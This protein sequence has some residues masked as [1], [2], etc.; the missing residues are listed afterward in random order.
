MGKTNFLNGCVLVSL[1][2]SLHNILHDD[3]DFRK[4]SQAHITVFGWLEDEK[5]S[6]S[7]SSISPKLFKGH[8][9]FKKSRLYSSTVC[10]P[11]GT[12]NNHNTRT[13]HTPGSSPEVKQNFSFTENEQGAVIEPF[14]NLA[15]KAIYKFL[16]NNESI[17]SPEVVEKFMAKQH[18]PVSTDFSNADLLCM[19]NFIIE[20]INIFLK[21]S[22]FHGQYKAN[23]VELLTNFK[24]NV[25]NK[26]AHGI[27]INEKGRWSDHALQH[28]AILACEVIICLDNKIIK[29]WID[30]ASQKR[31]SDA[32]FGDEENVDV[33]HKRR[34][35]DANFGNLHLI[36]LEG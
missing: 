10:G 16:V 34:L 11:Y 3:P 25:R 27:V 30:K 35:G 7:S 18:P 9:I 29:R 4:K 2:D 28:V 8:T 13:T 19:L 14:V 23:P 6:S 20:N 31:K 5:L 12:I 22:V 1:R 15:E 24:K 33:L 21:K 26:L 17:I 32:A 36:F